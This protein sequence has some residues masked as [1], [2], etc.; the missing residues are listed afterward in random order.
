MI[1]I[2]SNIFMYAAGAAHPNKIAS[3]IYL[4]GVAKGETDACTSVEILQEILHRYRHIA[5]WND[6]KEVYS[7]IKKIVPIIVSIDSEIIDRGFD[8]LEK[9]SSIYSRDA[10]HAATCFSM[11]IQKICSYDTDFDCI[12]GLLRIEPTGGSR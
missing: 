5:R 3:T 11:G 12:D 2:D 9:Y 8:L 10:V 6:G 4:H 7:L 1:F